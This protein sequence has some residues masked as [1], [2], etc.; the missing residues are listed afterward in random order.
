VRKITE[1]NAIGMRSK[2]RPKNRWRD[3]VL[4]GLK[5]LKAKNW[6]YLFKDRTAGVNGA[7]NRN[8]QRVVV[9]AE[10]E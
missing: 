9:S 7:E 8:T 2:G 6:A 4:N 5:T 1:W 3:E 10:E